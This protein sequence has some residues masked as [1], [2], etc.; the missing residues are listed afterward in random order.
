MPSGLTRDSL[1][2]ASKQ[3]IRNLGPKRM[4]STS[5]CLGSLQT[6]LHQRPSFLAL[7]RICLHLH[8]RPERII[9][10]WSSNS[11]QIHIACR[12]FLIPARLRLSHQSASDTAC[13]PSTA[14]RHPRGSSTALASKQNLTFSPFIAIILISPQLAEVEGHVACKSPCFGTEGEER[15][16]IRYVLTFLCDGARRFL[17]KNMP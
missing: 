17:A 3:L 14:H 1:F 7:S 13:A 4:I 16:L 9:R 6:P 12:L 2:N 15:P 11:E 8:D 10:F 5:L